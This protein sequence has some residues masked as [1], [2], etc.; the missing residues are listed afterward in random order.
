MAEKSVK[1]PELLQLD[2]LREPKS[3]YASTAYLGG[4]GIFRWVG[5]I[6]RRDY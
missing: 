5:D 2:T 1:V 3:T 6:P 4:L